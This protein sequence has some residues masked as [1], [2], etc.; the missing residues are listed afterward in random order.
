MNLCTGPPW[1]SLES[2]TI[3]TWKQSHILWSKCSWGKK[4]TNW[5][6]TPRY[7]CLMPWPRGVQRGRRAPWF[8]PTLALSLEDSHP[9]PLWWALVWD[10]RIRPI[11]GH[12]LRTL[13]KR[14]RWFYCFGLSLQHYGKITR[15]RELP[16]PDRRPS[17]QLSGTRGSRQTLPGSCWQCFNPESLGSHSLL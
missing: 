14:I 7:K 15:V 16:S 13:T 10:L 12:L 6:S 1:L 4:L 8:Y 2:G 11:Y 5:N 3:F 9:L 17:N